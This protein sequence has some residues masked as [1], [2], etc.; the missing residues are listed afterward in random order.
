LINR[1]WDAYLAEAKPESV[2]RIGLRYINDFRIIKADPLDPDVYLNFYPHIGPQLPQD[3]GNAQMSVLFVEAEDSTDALR[4]QFE[5]VPIFEEKRA[6]LSLDLDCF[7][8]D[9][10]HIELSEAMSNVERFHERVRR[11]FEASIT[12][13]LRRLLEPLSATEE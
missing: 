9:K 1:V 3:Y 7:S 13:E 4:A 6:T 8:L 10:I 5:T 12:E 2:A 11:F